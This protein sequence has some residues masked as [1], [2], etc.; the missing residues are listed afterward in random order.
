M[1]GKYSPTISQAYKQDQNWFN[2]YAGE[3]LY[4]PDG[5]DDYGY[6]CNGIDRAGKTE[7]DYQQVCEC[8]GQ[9][10]ENLFWQIRDE[11]SFDGVKPT[12]TG[13]V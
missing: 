10:H 13:E 1:K 5:Y 7:Y 4:D 12:K 8:C 9:N 3:N 11:W 2:K 6:D